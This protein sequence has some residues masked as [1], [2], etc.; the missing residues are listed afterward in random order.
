M[1][2]ELDLGFAV[3]RLQ[4]AL[5]ARMDEGLARHGLT[6]PQYAVLALLRH[7]PGRSNAELAR[8]SFVAPPTMI[9]IV[10]HLADAGLVARAA[11]AAGSRSRG[12]T[13]TEA[14]RARLD[15][16]GAHVRSVEDVLHVGL[17]DPARDVVRAWLRDCADRLTPGD[18]R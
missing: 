14:G 1:D 4:L 9:Q 15:A 8:A 5:R 2:S 3:K 18:A 17:G 7:E 12:I 11:P 10:T 6:A 16:A 13:L